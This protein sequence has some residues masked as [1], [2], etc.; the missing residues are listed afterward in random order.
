MSGLTRLAGLNDAEAVA[1]LVRAAFAEQ[2]RHFGLDRENCPSHPSLTDAAAIRR[3]LER[4]TRFLVIEQGDRL[5]GCIGVRQ[6]REDACAVEK[7]AVHPERQGQGLGTLLLDEAVRVARTDGARWL[8][9]STIDDNAA[10]KTWYARRG[11]AFVDLA[12][13]DHLPFAVAVLRRDLAL[14]A[15]S[16]TAV[17]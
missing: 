15:A 17:S 3:S 6:P 16:R 11:F 13:Y 5:C 10:L 4:G 14:Q 9:A 2:A 1:E 12:H 8:T 7:L